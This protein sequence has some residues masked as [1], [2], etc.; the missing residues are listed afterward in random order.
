[1]LAIALA[2]LVPMVGRADASV[3]LD[4]RCVEEPRDVAKPAVLPDEAPAQ[5]PADQEKAQ[6]KRSE[7]DAAARKALEQKRNPCKS[8]TPTV[9]EAWIDRVQNGVFSGVCGSA[10]WF[11]SFFG[12]KHV[13]DTSDL[14]G[15]VGLGALYKTSG[16]Y[17]GRSRFDANIPLPNMNMKAAAFVGRDNA[18]DYISQT[19]DALAVPA[20]FLRLSDDQ[21]WLAGLGYTP[22]DKR[23]NRFNFRL[24]SQVSVHPYVFGQARYQYD[25]YLD[26]TSALRLQE[27]LFY[28]SSADGL[29]LT[30]RVGYDWLPGENFFAR[31]S[32]S[33]SLTQKTKGV[34]WNAYAT[35]YQ[36]MSERLGRARGASFQLLVTGETNK[37][38]PLQEYGFLGVYREQVYRP[39]MFANVTLGYTFPRRE[40]TDRRQGA[41]NI[42]LFMEILFGNVPNAYG[43]TRPAAKHDE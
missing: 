16:E 30:T 31:L 39:W 23:L 13:Y 3:I 33:A 24:G 6:Q 37:D 1:M 34:K 5:T 17:D 18:N 29:G 26:A 25:R 43:G 27:V 38:V 41:V 40:I 8:R 14:Y 12:D 35:L 20:T 32:S 22:S 21:S 7:D 4:D 11:D 2:M 36:D 15:R 10:V 19:N 42:G 9:K 28:R